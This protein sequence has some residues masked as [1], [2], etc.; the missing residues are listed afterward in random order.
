M[1]SQYW[2]NTNYE[3]YIGSSMCR[4][5]WNTVMQHLEKVCITMCKC[6]ERVLKVF[7]TI[8]IYN[9]CFY[10]L[11]MRLNSSYHQNSVHEN[12]NE[13]LG[14]IR[15]TRKAIKDSHTKI[16]LFCFKKATVLYQILLKINWSSDSSAQLHNKCG[17]YVWRSLQLP[18]THLGSILKF[19]TLQA[20]DWWW[21]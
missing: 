3:L 11:I 4:S 7:S 21:Q 5:S 12:S 2:M 17:D 9:P 13:T 1:S 16:K 8:L 14:C 20:P 6:F 10:F 18:A 19:I 15:N